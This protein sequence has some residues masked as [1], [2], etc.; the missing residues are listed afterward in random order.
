MAMKG[1]MSSNVRLT[2][3]GQDS[4]CMVLDTSNSYCYKQHVHLRTPRRY[5]Q[6]KQRHRHPPSRKAKDYKHKDC[7][8]NLRSGQ[9][10]KQQPHATVTNNPRP[11]LPRR[12]LPP[13]I[14]NN[15]PPSR[16]CCCCFSTSWSLAGNSGRFT[17]VRHSSRKSRASHSYQCVGDF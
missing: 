7:L 1:L 14:N 3:L 11:Q 5:H 6:Q 16:F 12:P 17:W 2:L 4:S 10:Q 9:G 13:V 8:Y 15:Q